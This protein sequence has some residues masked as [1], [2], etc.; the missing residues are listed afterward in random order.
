[1]ADD[2]AD[3]AVV[4]G[5]DGEEGLGSRGARLVV[6]ESGAT[7]AL[8][9]LE[10]KASAVG[11]E[12]EHQER[13]LIGDGGGVAFLDGGLDGADL[14]ALALTQSN[15]GAEVVVS[16]GASPN[17]VPEP[18]TALLLLSGLAALGLRRR[19]R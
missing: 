10:G 12:V 19:R 15:L 6:G 4:E 8:G 11:V 1:M 9:D 7:Q 13:G 16:P 5:P 14:S 3:V 17:A 2:G 18:S